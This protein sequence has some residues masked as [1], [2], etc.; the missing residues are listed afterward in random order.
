MRHITWQ[1]LMWLRTLWP[2]VGPA[3]RRSI[4]QRALFYTL[5]VFNNHRRRCNG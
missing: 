1:Q 2:F 5:A 3:T 4:A